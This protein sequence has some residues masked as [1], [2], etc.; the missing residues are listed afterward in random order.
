MKLSKLIEQRE[1]EVKGLADRIDTARARQTGITT[2]VRRQGRNELTTVETSEYESLRA[3]IDA[4]EKRYD[5][6]K[7][8]L[9]ELQR[10]DAEET[11]SDA[12]ASQTV[13][14][15][16]AR[17]ATGDKVGSEG[18]TE[19]RGYDQ[20]HRVTS[21][22]RT[23]SRDSE[24]REGVSFINDLLGATL[25]RSNYD[26]AERLQRHMKEERVERGAKL[27]RAVGTGAFAGLTV[28]QY[29]TDLYAPAVAALS[30]FADACNKH[31]LPA[32]GMQLNISRIT[33]PS[34]TAIQSTEN[35]AV[36]NTDIDDT[37]LTI[38]VQTVAG[39]QVVSRQAIERGAG[40]EE[41]VMQDLMKRYAT[42]KDATL[43]NQAT[44]GLS[45]VATANAYTDASPTGPEFYPKILQAAAGSEAA[46]LGMASVDLAVM[47]SRRWYW[48]QSQMT[49]TWPMLGQS[50][51]PSQVAGLV[52]TQSKYGAGARGVLPSGLTVI[53]DNNVATNLGAGTNEDEVYVVPSDECHLWEDPSAPMFIRAEQPQ[54]ASLGVVLVVYGYLAYTFGRYPSAMQKIGG[55]GLITPAFS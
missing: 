11:R 54:V 36:Q 43:L 16:A 3:Q 19:Q 10:A 32:Q 24:Q 15:P 4:D 27:T 55:T 20:Q 13:E 38:N 17:A 46:L 14:T 50:G 25:D 45:A 53:V 23:Y 1:T 42:T 52:N 18:S 8:D 7:A 40:V 28:P 41:V 2:E 35:S 31:Q 12:A 33:T 37:L 6:A 22:K 39:Q 34:A 49:S 21:E 44:T 5:A 48:L 29:L 9:A 51:F 30:P 26:A 47:H